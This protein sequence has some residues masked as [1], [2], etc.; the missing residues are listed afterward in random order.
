MVTDF[1]ESI[2]K[3]AHEKNKG[4]RNEPRLI[5]DQREVKGNFSSKVKVKSM[6]KEKGTPLNQLT[7]FDFPPSP[8]ISHCILAVA[9]KWHS[10]NHLLLN[11][12]KYESTPKFETPTYPFMS[13]SQRLRD[14]KTN[15]EFP[16]SP[17]D[18]AS[19]PADE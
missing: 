7:I 5:M 4:K 10:R 12:S 16:W 1:K 19:I 17:V 18:A 8:I 9:R 15:A 14:R 13:D 11:D 6:I 2:V 3:R